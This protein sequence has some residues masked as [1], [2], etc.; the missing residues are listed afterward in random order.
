MEQADIAIVGAGAAGLMAAIHAGRAARASGRPVAARVVALDSARSLGAKILVAG[1]GRCNVTHDVVTERDYAG[2]T[3]GAIRTTLR[4]FTVEDTVG[5]F[6]ALGVEL[7]REETGKLFPVTDSAR[8]VLSALVNAAREAGAELRFPAR[9]D[10]IE[11]SEGGFTLRGEWGAL[12][13]G[14]VALATGGLSLPKSGSDGR[15]LRIAQSLGHSVTPWLLPA[16]VPL[17]LS[18]GAWQRALAGVAS[19]AVVEV[20]G[21][22][23]RRLARFEGPAL[24]AHFGLTGPSVMDA[25]RHLLHARL[26]DPG[27]QLVVGW[28]PGL[29]A[30]SLDAELVGLGGRTPLSLLRAHMPERLARALCERCGVDAGAPGS[31]LTRDARR[32]LARLAAEGPAEVE[33]A[34]GWN[35]A[36]ATAGGVPLRE[37]RLETMESRVC[38]GLHLCGEALDV[39]GRIGGYNF[40]WAWATGFIA[41]GAMGGALS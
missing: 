33:G 40:Q 30:E 14:R 20:R 6:R 37:V 10:A 39:D 16:L 28:T 34:R 32:A 8:T 11:R 22:T 21:S 15:G 26:E 27:A 17:T 31:R 36:E 29:T 19:G 2:S 12:R 13:A 3:P 18:A 41:G 25:S 38:P 4:R 1:G 35:Y 24:C 23:G 7:K 9:V 5:F